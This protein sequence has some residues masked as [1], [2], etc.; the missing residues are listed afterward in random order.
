M[1]QSDKRSTT[2]DANV[3]LDADDDVPIDVITDELAR[4]IGQRIV[5]VLGV[6]RQ[7]IGNGKVRYSIEVTAIRRMS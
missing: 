6:E 3:E 2:V 1:P 4:M 7:D 5:G